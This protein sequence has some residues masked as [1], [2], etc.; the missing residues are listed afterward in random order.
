M[1]LFQ[2]IL[3]HFLLKFKVQREQPQ[4]SEIGDTNA[5]HKINFQAEITIPKRMKNLSKGRK[6]SE[7]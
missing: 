3:H 6:L 5:L 2:Y 7:L 4:T 1:K